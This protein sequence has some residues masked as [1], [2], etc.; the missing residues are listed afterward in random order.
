MTNPSKARNILIKICP[1][2]S[3]F[4]ATIPKNCT[5]WIPKLKTAIRD[6]ASVGARETK[7]E[8]LKKRPANGSTAREKHLRTATF[9]RSNASNFLHCNFLHYNFY[10][11]K[12]HFYN[13]IMFIIHRNVSFSFHEVLLLKRLSMFDTLNRDGNLTHQS[14]RHNLT[15]SGPVNFFFTRNAQKTPFW[16]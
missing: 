14:C 9:P 5:F 4:A 6:A 15:L 11:C 1:Y 3:S 2:G 12:K 8:K 16:E 7:M 10:L 13:K